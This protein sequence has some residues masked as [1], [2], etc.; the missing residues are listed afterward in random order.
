[1]VAGDDFK[2]SFLTQRAKE[3]PVDKKLR[4]LDYLATLL[5]KEGLYELGTAIR[6]LKDPHNIKDFYNV[7]KSWILW[8]L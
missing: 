7:L 2:M 4:R 1:M 3:N 6:N 5:D 8:I